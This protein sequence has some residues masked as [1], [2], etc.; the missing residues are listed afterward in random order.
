MN[1]IKIEISKNLDEQVN[2]YR[3]NYKFLAKKLQENIGIDFKNMK[4]YSSYKSLIKK[5]NN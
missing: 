3:R 4:Q 5:I 1:E 2:I